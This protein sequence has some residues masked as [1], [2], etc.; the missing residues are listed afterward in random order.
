MENAADANRVA[1]SEFPM[2]LDQALH[3]SIDAERT[4]PR[5]T[6]PTRRLLHP[7]RHCPDG[8]SYLGWRMI[9]GQFGRMV[10]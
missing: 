9:L 10:G 5:V 4:A 3:E 6:P 7:S 2:R 1:Y 8:G